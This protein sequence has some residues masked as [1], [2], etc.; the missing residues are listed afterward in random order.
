MAKTRVYFRLSSRLSEKGEGSGKLSF[1]L[2]AQWQLPFCNTQEQS[3]QQHVV[4]S[5]L[6]H[7]SISVC[8]FHSPSLPETSR[9]FCTRINVFG[10]NEAKPTEISFFFSGKG[11][12][13]NFSILG[14]VNGHMT[15]SQ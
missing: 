14:L 7:F 1:S 13:N 6:L 5:A 2:S 12:L 10:K 11:Y 8:M 4:Q 3:L 9:S 15:F